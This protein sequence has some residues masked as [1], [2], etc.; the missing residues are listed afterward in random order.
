MNKL[1]DFA[2]AIERLTREEGF[3]TDEDERLARRAHAVVCV[4][5]AATLLLLVI[6]VGIFPAPAFGG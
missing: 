5:A 6:C 2:S 1:R 4:G 3:M